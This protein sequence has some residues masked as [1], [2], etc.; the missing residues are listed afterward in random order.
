M[1]KSLL[2]LLSLLA[3]ITGADNTYPCKGTF[4]YSLQNRMNVSVEA[5]YNTA[6]YEGHCVT[7]LWKANKA[8]T[9]WKNT[10]LL[11]KPRY[12]YYSLFQAISIL[13]CLR[14]LRLK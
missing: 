5:M 9:G 11:T 6:W 14:K 3:C 13:P 2:V 1:M 12:F 4:I 10:M 7:P 8:Y